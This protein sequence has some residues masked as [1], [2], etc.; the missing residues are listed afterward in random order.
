MFVTATCFTLQKNIDEIIETGFQNHEKMESALIPMKK[1][2]GIPEVVPD[3]PFF[4][5]DKN[6]DSYLSTIVMFLEQEP[7]YNVAMHLDVNCQQVH[8][9]NFESAQG[10]NFKDEIFKNKGDSF[11]NSPIHLMVYK[12]MKKEDY[13]EDYLSIDEILITPDNI[14]QLSSLSFSGLRQTNEVILDKDSYKNE[15]L[16]VLE[17]F[18][19]KFVTKEKYQQLLF[20]LGEKPSNGDLQN[21]Y[22]LLTLFNHYHMGTIDNF[23]EMLQYFQFPFV[24]DDKLPLSMNQHLFKDFF[25]I[26]LISD[27][28]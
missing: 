12:K 5:I 3:D 25:L 27:V 13:K 16:L 8:Q 10:T 7:Y 9:E 28:Q 6:F 17:D 15:Y 26:S 23:K 20:I 21:H 24:Y 2:S 1:L 19:A 22:K 11:L 18:T 4:D 14:P